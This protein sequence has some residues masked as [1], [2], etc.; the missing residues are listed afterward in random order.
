MSQPSQDAVMTRH[1]QRA[2]GLSVAGAAIASAILLLLHPETT[3]DRARQLTIIAA[4]SGT[5]TV[6][7]VLGFFVLAWYIPVVIGLGRLAGRRRPRLNAI[8]VTLGV[9]GAVAVAAINT[10]EVVLTKMAAFPQAR[11]QMVNLYRQISPPH[12]FVFPLELGLTVALCLL[13]FLLWEADAIP[14]WTSV[15]LAIGALAEFVGHPAAV[16]ALVVSG[17]FLQAA[18][19]ARIGWLIVKTSETGKDSSAQTTSNVLASTGIDPR[20]Q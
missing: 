14:A 17:A 19:A 2:L 6:V 1:R 10:I 13:A 5:W 11:P 16:Q 20:R 7:H 12:L 8:A 9:L 4:H 3:A 15:A 18:A